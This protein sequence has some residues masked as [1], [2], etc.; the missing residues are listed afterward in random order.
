MSALQ[1]GILTAFSCLSLIV[2]LY[3]LIFMVPVKRFL[4]RIRSLGGGLE[5]VQTHV[6]GVRD[7]IIRR[8]QAVEGRTEEQLAA[9]A[10]DLEKR[11]RKLHKQGD[12]AKRRLD[13]A[14]KDLESIRDELGATADG[15]RQALQRV[16]TLSS[17]LEQMRTEFEALEVELREAIR[18]EVT[19]SFSTVESRALAALD[20]IQEQILYGATES[21]VPPP[22]AP[23]RGPGAGARRK[24]GN[25][26]SVEPL[27]ANP[28]Q[29]EKGQTE[30]NGEQA[31]PLEED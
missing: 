1:I 26:I 17:R 28:R 14:A 19:D 9:G 23:L 3:C 24:R 10:E 20:A 2:A 8:L 15:A 27:F 5:G 31:P 18:R 11:L 16:E 12:A 29:G 13:T 30:R 6:R 4:E 25:I 7:D 21:G 22:S